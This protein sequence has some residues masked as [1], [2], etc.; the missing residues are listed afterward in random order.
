MRGNADKLTIQV[1]I[2]VLKYLDMMGFMV[3]APKTTLKPPKNHPKT[4]VKPT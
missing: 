3:V 1:D 2:N 4:T